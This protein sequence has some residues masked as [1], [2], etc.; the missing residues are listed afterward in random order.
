[1]GNQ[2]EMV[3]CQY[4]RNGNTVP[5]DHAKVFL[6][7]KLNHLISSLVHVGMVS[8]LAMLE[9]VEKTIE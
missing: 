3:S 1:M 6:C 2:F 9:Q 4:L 7:F 5:A 8:S